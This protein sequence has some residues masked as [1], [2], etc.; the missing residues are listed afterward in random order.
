VG[1][2]LA[3]G[4][5]L[6]CGGSSDV[7]ECSAEEGEVAAAA[8]RAPLA[9]KVSRFTTEQVQRCFARERDALLALAGAAA[10]GLV[11]TLVATGTRRG[12]AADWPLLLLQP[13]GQSLPSW[14]AECV[15]ADAALV[16]GEA[17]GGGGGGGG[18]SSQVRACAARAACA[19]AVVLRLLDALEAAH[20]ASLVHCD[21]RPSNVVVVR[22]RSMLVD[23]GISRATGA[24]AQ[25]CGVA[26]YADT[27]VFEQGV[28]Q[29]RPAQDVIGALY[30]WL[31]VAHSEQCDAP[32]PATGA[33]ET[34]FAGRAAWL[35]RRSGEDAVVAR[36]VEALREAEGRRSWAGGEE[37]L[38]ALARKALT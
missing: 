25:G 26:A 36:V 32:W 9:A 7:Y 21:V 18:G 6:G 23:W 5:R 12:G 28:Y 11:P 16:G 27:R 37:A 22:G 2:L 10:R 1:A 17:G 35:K 38:Y 33:L 15:A 3:L 24:A 19:S 30:T 34:M 4:T 31:C 8:A 29:A 14:V 20:A 13:C